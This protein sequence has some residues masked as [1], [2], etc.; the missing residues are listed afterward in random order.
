MIAI[1]HT[2][3]PVID[4]GPDD[5]DLLVASFLTR[6]ASEMTRRAYDADL[7][8]FDKWCRG[9]GVKPLDVTRRDV[10]LYCRTMEAEGLAKRTRCRRVGTVSMFFKTLMMDGLADADPTVNVTRPRVERESTTNGL[11]RTELADIF[12]AAEKSS[13]PADLAL[14]CLLGLNGMRVAEACSLRIE[15]LG[16][17]RGMVTITFVRKGGKTA[18]APLSPMTAWAVQKCTEGR[19]EGAILLNRAGNPMTT[20]NAW[21]VVRRLAKQVGIKKRI[22]PH[23]FRHAFVTLSLDAGVSQRDVQNSTGHADNRMLLYYDRNRESLQRHATH[24]L[25]AY[26]AGTL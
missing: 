21:D 19:D 2:H 23:S 9:R 17:E 4:K 13:H 10:E 7:R 3:A 14:V 1:H 20:H 26:V 15:D 8:A 5:F 24:T 22:S 16:G 12:T 6:Y 25:T 11:R 18:K